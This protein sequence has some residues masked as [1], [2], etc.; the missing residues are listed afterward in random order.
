MGID[1]NIILGLKTYEPA[2]PMDVMS[3][4][5]TMKHLAAMAKTNEADLAIKKMSMQHMALQNQTTMRDLADSQALRDAYAA[6]IGED[7]TINQQGVI[8]SVGKSAPQKVMDLQKLFQGHNLESMQYQA[9]L[10]KNLAWSATP[11]NWSQIRQSAIEKGLQ[12][13]DKLPPVYDE[14]F[15]KNWQMH[16]LDGEKQL[17]QQNADRTADRDD[18]KADQTDERLEIEGRKANAAMV[19]AQAG[20]ARHVT[21]KQNQ[22]MQQTVQ[23]LES[24]RG[25]PAVGQAEKDIYAVNK[26]DSLVNLYGDPN[27]LN[28]AQ[29]QLV[30]TEVAKI[31]SGGVP[32][33]HELQGLNPSTI[34]SGLAKLAQTVT[35]KP[36]P[37]NA[38]AFVKAMQDYGVS[39]KKDAQSVIQDKYGRVI[40][41]KRR[42]LTPEDY[43][44]LNDQYISRFSESKKS[45]AP[46]TRVMDGV[47]YEKVQ[48]G[49]KAK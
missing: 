34:S 21:D 44:S 38:G 46:E 30:A 47:T 39:L 3:K 26:L 24:A 16:T 42:S 13:A 8:A 49:W 28:P 31:A 20:R 22:S 7:G 48:G 27:K 19:T 40:E 29:V 2:S 18:R 1:P 35:N 33:I 45:A 12:N 4:A 43:Q 23:L 36:T 11:E 9:S 37:A 10:A 17:A 14:A 15:A 6:N 5:M 32:S 25:N 41:S